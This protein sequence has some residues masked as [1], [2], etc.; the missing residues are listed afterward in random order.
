LPGASDATQARLIA[1]LGDDRE[2]YPNAES[3]QTASGIAPLTT[4]SGR[5]RF[6]SHRWACTKF[7]KQTFHE[8]A[9]LSRAK[10]QWADAYYRL[11]ISRQKSPQMALRSLAYKWQRIIHRLWQDGACYDDAKYLQ[12][13]RAT[14]SPLLAFL[15]D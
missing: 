15:T 10:C 8:Y 5:Q 1:A 12:Q 14:N 9:G 13:L 3:L 4:Q 7:I 2:R 6:V 11:Q